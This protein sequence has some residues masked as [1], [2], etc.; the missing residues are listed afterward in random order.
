MKKL[1]VTGAKKKLV[2]GGFKNVTGAPFVGVVPFNACSTGNARCRS[3]RNCTSACSVGGSMV[4]LFVPTVSEKEVGCVGAVV[5]APG[6]VSGEKRGA[7]PDVIGWMTPWNCVVGVGAGAV[8]VKVTLLVSSESSGS[9]SSTLVCR[10][11]NISTTSASCTSFKFV[12][13]TNVLVNP[14]PFVR[15]VT[16]PVRG[17]TVV[18]AEAEAVDKVRV[19]IQTPHKRAIAKNNFFITAGTRGQNLCQPFLLKPTPDAMM[20]LWGEDPMESESL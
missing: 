2:A 6:A 12:G 4:N 14:I 9:V 1:F 19:P 7:G 11:I 15:G 16:I 3:S 10:V 17:I 13:C 20:S 8:A 5:L 18:C